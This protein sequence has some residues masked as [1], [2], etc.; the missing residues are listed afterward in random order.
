MGEKKDFSGAPLKRKIQRFNSLVGR[1]QDPGSLKTRAEQLKMLKSGEQFDV[2]IVG[3]GCTGS[4]SA[5]D[6]ATRGL[7][8]ACIERGDFSNE[9]SSRSS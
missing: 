8:V 7:K 9:T 2:V 6:A 3:A 5:L 1:G 4:G